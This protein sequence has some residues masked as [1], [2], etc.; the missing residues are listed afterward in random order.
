MKRTSEGERE[1][2]A[3]AKHKFNGGKLFAIDPVCKS[4][5]AIWYTAQ[6]FLVRKCFERGKKKIRNKLRLT[7][8]ATY[9]EAR[10]CNHACWEKEINIKYKMVQIWPGQTVTCLHTIS[11]GHI[12][13]TLYFNAFHFWG[14]LAHVKSLRQRG[15]W[16]SDATTVCG[17]LMHCFTSHYHTFTDHLKLPNTTL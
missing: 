4:K 12:W 9:N 13:T 11:P 15:S 8:K 17:I 5:L 7:R 6:I 14:L 16:S 2:R 3:G 1:R 10:S